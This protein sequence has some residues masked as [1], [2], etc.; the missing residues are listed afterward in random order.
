[1]S[2]SW[3]C[4]PPS[5]WTGTG[6]GAGED[7]DDLTDQEAL[8]AQKTK[9]FALPGRTPEQ[10]RLAPLLANADLETLEFLHANTGLFQLAAALWNTTEEVLEEILD[11]EP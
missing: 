1:M 9:V 4:P 7:P 2:D 5:P 3:A 11:Q 10:D 8:A 6:P